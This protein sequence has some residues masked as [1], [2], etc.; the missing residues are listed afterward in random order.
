M[1][2]RDGP[3][4]TRT[5][6]IPVRSECS[7][8]L[9]YE[10]VPGEIKR[11]GSLA[12]RDRTALEPDGM[13]ATDAGKARQGAGKDRMRAIGDMFRVMVCPDRG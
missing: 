13:A 6:D 7:I 9:S 11:L 5:C 2:F 10:F 1:Y 12:D 3:G 8:L 4:R